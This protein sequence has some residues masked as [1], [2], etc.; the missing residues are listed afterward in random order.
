IILHVGGRFRLK[1]RG[2]VRL[3]IYTRVGLVALRIR[4]LNA[5]LQI[6][7]GAIELRL[8]K[9]ESLHPLAFDE[10][11]VETTLNA[12]ISNYG[13]QREGFRR[14]NETTLAGGCVYERWIW[15][16]GYLRE[17]IV[18]HRAEQAFNQAL[19][20]A[21]GRSVEALWLLVEQS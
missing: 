13:R 8:Q 1:E 7:F 12:V 20:V 6:F 10:Q 15:L 4:L 18:E 2:D 16:L 17:A 11:R 14:S 5:A 9:P 3:G 21:R 19:P